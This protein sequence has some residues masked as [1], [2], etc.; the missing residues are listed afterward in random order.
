MSKTCW[1]YTVSGKKYHFVFDYTWLSH[2]LVDFFGIFIPLKTGMTW[3]RHNCETSPAMKV[4]YH[5][6]YKYSTKQIQTVSLQPNYVSTL[7]GKTRNST[8]TADHYTAV[9]FVEP[10]VPAFNVPFFPYLLDNSFSSLLTELL[11]T[12]SSVFIKNLSSNS[13]WLIL[14]CKLKL[15]CREL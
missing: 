11:F 5:W 14:T 6:K 8:K 12:F 3:W 15:N 7:P 4:L 9:R 1:M 2:F 10:I 13:I